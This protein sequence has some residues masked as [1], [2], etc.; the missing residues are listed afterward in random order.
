MKNMKFYAGLLTVTT[1]ILI[2]IIG[3]NLRLREYVESKKWVRFDSRVAY[4]IDGDTII[5]EKNNMHV[6]FLGIDAPELHHPDVPAQ[7]YG[8]EARAYLDNMISNKTVTLEFCADRKFDVYGRLLAYIY[9]NGRL[10]NSDMVGN[11]FAYVYLKSVCSK[12]D[13]LLA[14]EKQARESKKGLWKFEN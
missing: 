8:E 4:V 10:V 1:L 9:Y 13:E 7:R 5:I 12:Q 6:R 2:L 11:G 3:A 14:L